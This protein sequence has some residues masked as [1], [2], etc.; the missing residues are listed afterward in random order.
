MLSPYNDVASV[1]T[2]VSK[3]SLAAIVAARSDLLIFDEKGTKLATDRVAGGN[4]RGR[5][6][7]YPELAKPAGGQCASSL[8]TRCNAARG[9]S[10]AVIE[11]PI[12]R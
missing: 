2:S 4:F 1:Q 5:I 12:T 11:R 7:L 10:A 6:H 9:S 3:K 8:S